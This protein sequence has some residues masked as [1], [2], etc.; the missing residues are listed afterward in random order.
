MDTSRII[1]IPIKLTHW[2]YLEKLEGLSGDIQN[3][4]EKLDRWQ[5]LEKLNWW[6]NLEELEEIWKIRNKYSS[7][8]KCLIPNSIVEKEKLG[9]KSRNLESLDRC[10]NHEK[11]EYIWKIGN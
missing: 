9:D 5:N 4:I 7:I 6:Q 1:G 8:W 11:L 10:H 2:I 3:Q